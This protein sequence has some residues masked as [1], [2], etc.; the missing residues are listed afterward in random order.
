MKQSSPHRVHVDV[1]VVGAG[2]AGAHVAQLLAHA[3]IKTALIDQKPLEKSGPAWINAVSPWFFKEAALAEPSGS[4]IFDLNNRFIMREP[5]KAFRLVIE[6]LNVYDLHM[7][8][9]G[10]R[11]KKRFLEKKSA[12]FIRGEACTAE[13]DAHR[14]LKTIHVKSETSSYLS[15]HAELFIDASGNRAFLR[16]AHPHAQSLWPAIAPHDMCT[17]AQMT[18]AINDRHGAESFLEKNKI[19]PHDV[20]ADVGFAGGYSLLRVQVDRNF[21]T[22][23]LLA[24]IRSD[25]NLPS[26]LS[27][28]QS[29]QKEHPWLGKAIISGQGAIPLNAPYYRLAS[30]GLALLGDSASQVYAAHGSGIGM[31]LVA[32]RMLADAII[33]S[34]SQGRDI[35]LHKSLSAYERNFHQKYYRRLY[36][37]EHFRRF[38]QDLS[39]KETRSL[40]ESGLL[41]AEMSRQTLRQ[42]DPSLSPE[43]LR[44]LLLGALKAPRA[45][46]SMLPAFHHAIKGKHMASRL[47]KLSHMARL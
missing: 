40:L 5:S 19:L 21:D 22:L 9:L 1:A 35:G 34:Q 41:N 4:E 33:E 8:H 38:S 43:A 11:L 28:A 26:A 14:R 46:I 13:F 3:G 18:F 23:S 7:G 45:F 15:V 32:A 20:I 30:P 39:P 12:L 27:I 10:Q 25:K 31:G 47:S 44:K 2:I 36:F 29:F 16:K 24:G 6:D 17:A 42:E 37:A